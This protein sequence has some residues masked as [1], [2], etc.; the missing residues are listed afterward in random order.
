[1]TK[2]SAAVLG[3]REGQS[4]GSE[5]AASRRHF[6]AGFVVLVALSV[7]VGFLGGRFSAT[8]LL[9]SPLPPSSSS[10]NYHGYPPLYGKIPEK[11]FWFYYDKGFNPMPSKIV[12]LCIQTFCHNNPDWNVEFVD[13]INIFQYLHPTALPTKFF[14]MSVPANKKDVV[15]AALLAMYGGAAIDTTVINLKSLTP[16]WDRMVSEGKSAHIFWYNMEG[17]TWDGSD[18]AAAYFFMARRDTGI[19]RRYSQDIVMRTGDGIDGS[20]FSHVGD[21]VAFAGHSLEPIIVEIDSSL[22]VC[23]TTKPQDMCIPPKE[24]HVSGNQDLNNVKVTLVDPMNA[25]MGIQFGWYAWTAL[26]WKNQSEQGVVPGSVEPK[27]DA[28]LQSS[29]GELWKAYLHRRQHEEFRMIKTFGAGGEWARLHPDKL[30]LPLETPDSEH[31]IL[32][33]WFHDAGLDPQSRATCNSR[34]KSAEESNGQMYVL[35]QIG[36][37]FCPTG[38]KK[39]FEKEECHTAAASFLK[40]PVGTWK[41]GLSDWIEEPSGCFLNMYK[42]VFYNTNSNGRA[43]VRCQPICKLATH[44]RKER[45]RALGTLETRDQK[46]WLRNA[47]KKPASTSQR[48]SVQE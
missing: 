44:Q 29:A 1:M 9:S 20:A 24:H 14:E 15:V 17:Q 45:A 23:A 16:M 35:G 4:Q 37:N 27:P 18:T 38:T 3:D 36:T 31:N 10:S 32:S 25:D 39:V 43:N 28:N 41:G 46:R 12:D 7:G 6:Y 8:G 21:Y 30:L 34:S 19:F 42:Q 2:F 22:P 13:D 5:S 26:G 33:K 47:G 48:I 11:T 40:L